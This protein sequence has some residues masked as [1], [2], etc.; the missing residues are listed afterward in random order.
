[1]GLSQRQIVLGY[2][3]FCAAFGLLALLLSSRL[4]KLLLLIALAAVTL[5]FLWWVEKRTGG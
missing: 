4:Y 5:A 1:M 3:A 2:Y